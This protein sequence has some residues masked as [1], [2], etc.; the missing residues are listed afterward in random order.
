MEVS[1]SNSPILWWPGTQ[2]PC[3]PPRARAH[4]LFLTPFT[5]MT[6]RCGRTPH[7]GDSVVVAICAR[8][9]STPRFSP[10]TDYLVQYNPAPH[11]SP[12]CISTNFSPFLRCSKYSALQGRTSLEFPLSF[13]T[14]FLLCANTLNSRPFLIPR[15]K[16]TLNTTFWPSFW[17]T[18][19]SSHR[20]S[21][22]HEPFYSSTCCYLLSKHASGTKVGFRRVSSLNLIYHL[23]DNI[24]L[25][26]I[27]ILSD[28]N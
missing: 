9:R 13:V 25:F 7:H 3:C 4:S 23:L 1:T 6:A 19:H 26:I 12:P 28:L 5:R 16:S 14:I 20:C 17:F 15:K 2:G 18:N 11:R 10:K 21:S 24:H 27:L 22:S 8:R